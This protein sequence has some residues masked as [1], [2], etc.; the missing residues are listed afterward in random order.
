MLVATIGGAQPALA[1]VDNVVTLHGCVVTV[2]DDYVVIRGGTSGAGP[3]GFYRLSLTAATAID[4]PTT[5][6]AC[7]VAVAYEQDGVW[8]AQSITVDR[9]EN[10]EVQVTER[11]GSRPA[12]GRPR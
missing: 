12:P 6:D 8:Y 2:G 10:G 9:D 4:A 3:N 7:I 5:E 11:E 1:D